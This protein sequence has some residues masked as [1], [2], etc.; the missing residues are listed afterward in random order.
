MT[1][2]ALK[3]WRSSRL[4][5]IDQ[6][7]AVHPDSIGSSTDPGAAAELTEALV[8]RLASEFQ[9][10][11]R[12]LH[13]DVIEVVIKS[14]PM[15]SSQLF[16]TL[17]EGLAEGRGLDR[18]G[19][20]PKTIGDDFDRL[21][22]SLWPALGRASPGAASD[23]RQALALLHRAR[24]GVAHDDREAVAEVGQLGW[25]VQFETVLRWRKVLDELVEAI[26]D[27]L[28]REIAV[29]IGKNPWDER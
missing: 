10:F 20:D 8:V 7:L 24:N 15:L 12:D 22:L 2:P 14:L 19:A 6:L 17:A 26:E 25:P 13:D 4:G 21:G 18:R 1:S 23:W 3:T 27:A 9:G 5:R 11:C 28:E 29:L 16:T